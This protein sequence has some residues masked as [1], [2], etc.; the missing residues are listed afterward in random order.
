MAG[1]RQ[2]SIRKRA[3]MALPTKP[4]SPAAIGRGRCLA[5]LPRHLAIRASSC[6]P[7]S[8]RFRRLVPKPVFGQ[9]FDAPCRTNF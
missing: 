8:G 5:T 6:R 7:W 9:I 3:D 2:P 4:S 1:G